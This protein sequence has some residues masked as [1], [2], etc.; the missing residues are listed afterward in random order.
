LFAIR[1]YR[2]GFTRIGIQIDTGNV[3]AEDAERGIGLFD[4]LLYCFAFTRF[5]FQMGTGDVLAEDAED[6][7][8]GIW[9]FGF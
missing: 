1:F 4:I 6:A 8:E 2:F 9:L 7:G 5:K 3:L